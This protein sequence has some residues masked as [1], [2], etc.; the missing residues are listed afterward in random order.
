MSAAKGYWI[1]E[2]QPVTNQ[3]AMAAYAAAWGS[4]AERFQAQMQVCTNELQVVEGA[5]AARVIVVA[6]ASYQT[7]LACYHSTEYQQAKSHALQAMQR[8]FTIVAGMEEAV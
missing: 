4:I 1:I 8:R 3:E 5:G 6:F 2:C 7:A